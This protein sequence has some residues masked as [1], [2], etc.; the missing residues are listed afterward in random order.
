ML[1]ESLGKIRIRSVLQ[2]QSERIPEVRNH[3][4]SHDVSAV[5]IFR[6]GFHLELLRFVSAIYNDRYV[7]TAAFGYPFIERPLP[8][9]IPLAQS[10]LRLPG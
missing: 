3:Q 8:P 1:K 6:A 7:L 9:P 2:A 10:S 5:P 4:I